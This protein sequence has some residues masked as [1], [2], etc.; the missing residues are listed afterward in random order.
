MNIQSR[1]TIILGTIFVG[2]LSCGVANAAKPSID[3]GTDEPIP[4]EFM[5]LVEFAGDAVDLSGLD[6]GLEDSSPSNRL[7]GFSAIEYSGKGNRFVILADRGAGDGAVSYPCRMQYVDLQLDPKGRS[8]EANWVSTVLLKSLDGAQL[9]G[10][11]VT[12]NA[13]RSRPA[14]SPWHAMDPEGI[15]RWGKGWLISEEYGPNIGYFDATGQLQKQWQLPESRVRCKFTKDELFNGKHS[16][17]Q[18][19]GSCE[20]RGLEGLAVTPSGSTAWASYQSSLLQ[21]GE[22]VD[23]KC[24]G[25]FTRWIA[26][27]QD[28]KL[29]AEVA[30]P[31]SSRYSGIS[32]LLSVDE[33]RLLVLE[34]DGLAGKDAMIKRIYLANTQ[35][36]SDVSKVDALPV[37]RSKNLSRPNPIEPV[38]KRLLIDL[39]EFQHELGAAATAEKPEGLTWGPAL[40]DG[41]RTLWIC[42]DNDFDPN[43]KS[44]IACFAVN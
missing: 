34:R 29:T 27:D 41:R 19:C 10:S 35:K 14:N 28:G 26:L 11:N 13:D 20:N 31:M 6:G 5:G 15:R 8:I 1:K 12:A 22:L 38:Q 21:D 18:L 43:L 9:D 4:I 32:E 39:M 17:D 30:Y 36:A 3:S 40:E 16:S 25:E 7:G 44:Y 23:G 37:D 24:F 2:L 33:H 42:W